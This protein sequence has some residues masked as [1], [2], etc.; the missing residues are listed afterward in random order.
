MIIRV[1]EAFAGISSP[2]LSLHG[3]ARL[4]EVV[5]LLTAS[6]LYAT[7]LVVDRGRHG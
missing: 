2:F 3:N 7:N 5:W 6:L 1:L 4:R